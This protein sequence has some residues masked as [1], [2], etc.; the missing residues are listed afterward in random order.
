MILSSTDKPGCKKETSYTVT[1]NCNYSYKDGLYNE[2][3]HLTRKYP[4]IVMKC[5]L[6]E[7]T[8][9]RLCNGEHQISKIEEV[10]LAELRYYNMH[11]FRNPAFYAPMGY[12]SYIFL[13]NPPDILHNFCAGLMKSLVRFILTIVHN[14]GKISEFSTII[15]GNNPASSESRSF[16][17]TPV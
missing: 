11:S 2:M 9:E 16:V 15:A 12:D 14:L 13:A 17:N 4:E 1:H 6:A 7:A 10:N 5:S 8:S 3:V